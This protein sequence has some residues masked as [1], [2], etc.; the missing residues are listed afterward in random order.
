MP[1]VRRSSRYSCNR[2]VALSMFRQ[3]TLM[4]A[5]HGRFAESQAH[6]RTT[7]RS[8]KTRRRQS[9][10]YLAATIA[11]VI[12]FTPIIASCGNSID[13][14]QSNPDSESSREIRVIESPRTITIEDLTGL[15]MKVGKEYDVATLEKATSANLLY[16]RVQGTAVE[17]EIRM[18]GNHADAVDFGTAPAEEGSGPDAIIDVDDAI[19]KEGVRDRRTI[20]DFRAEP[21]PKYG[22][23]G[24][25]A[26]IVMLCEGRDDDEAWARCQALIDQ[27]SSN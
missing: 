10:K 25:Y 7:R 15:G 9:L 17:Y 1:T 18:Y 12:A 21:K 4:A 13:A 23:Y 24:I 14:P 22:A 2:A 16:W 26:N 27:L 3:L 20:F 6:Q 8:P 5:R 11:T 19:Y